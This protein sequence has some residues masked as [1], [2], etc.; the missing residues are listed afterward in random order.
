MTPITHQRFFAHASILAGTARMV[1][2][3]VPWQN[4]SL[5]LQTVA[6]LID[7]GF[8]AGLLG[9]YLSL[10]GRVDGPL[11]LVQTTGFFLGFVGIASIVGPDAVMFGVDFYALGGGVAL[12]GLTL[13]STSWLVAGIG[14]R[15][16]TICWL[17]TF[18]LALATP[19]HPQAFAAMGFLFGAGFLCAGLWLH[20]QHKEQE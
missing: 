5:F 7:I 9:L 1:L 15:A 11:R 10:A 14:P 13:L 2:A 8:L 18:L 16:A 19:F 3:F 6:A 12:L 4:D 20:A 17:G